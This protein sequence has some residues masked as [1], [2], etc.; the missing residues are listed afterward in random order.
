MDA[1]NTVD[2][3]HPAAHSCYDAGHCVPLCWPCNH[4]KNNLPGDVHVWRADCDRRARWLQ[5][6][7]SQQPAGARVPPPDADAAAFQ[8]A[9][10]LEINLDAGV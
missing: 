6:L 8:A 1:P 10:G 7:Q 5:S 3:L 2:R 9:C 4:D